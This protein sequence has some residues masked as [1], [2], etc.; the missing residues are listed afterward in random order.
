MS[1]IK[2]SIRYAGVPR[3]TESHAGNNII[4]QNFRKKFCHKS[5]QTWLRSMQLAL[6]IYGTLNNRWLTA[7]LQSTKKLQSHVTDILKNVNNYES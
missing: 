3:S 4:S 7:L 6:K 5:Y 1:N 2:R